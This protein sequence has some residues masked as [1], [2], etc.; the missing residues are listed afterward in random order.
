MDCDSANPQASPKACAKVAD[1]YA[2][3]T[4]QSTLP[5]DCPCVTQFPGFIDAVNGP[6]QACFAGPFFIATELV[7]LF[8]PNPGDFAPSSDFLSDFGGGCG[9]FSDGRFSITEQQGVACNNLLKQ[10]AAAAGVT[11]QSIF[12]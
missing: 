9:N 2:K 3:I 4:G 1:N 8:P 5:C 11:C 6:I 10:R 7:I 12:P